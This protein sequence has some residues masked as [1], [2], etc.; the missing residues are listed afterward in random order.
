MA[1]RPLAVARGTGR[2]QGCVIDILIGGGG[3]GGSMG[4]EGHL[5]QV[6]VRCRKAE[7]SD[8]VIPTL[9]PL[10]HRSSLIFRR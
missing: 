2:R 4:G 3:G 6:W 10:N 7:E 1:Y 9:S 8:Y 5:D